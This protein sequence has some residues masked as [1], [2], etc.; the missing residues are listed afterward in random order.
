MAGPCRAETWW[1]PHVDIKTSYD[2]GNLGSLFLKKEGFRR[3]YLLE[4]VLQ[5]LATAAG[6]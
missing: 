5:K 3:F 1:A 4:K 2:V 6:T